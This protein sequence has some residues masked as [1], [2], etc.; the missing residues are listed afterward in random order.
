MFDF[1][2]GEK[3]QQECDAYIGT[4]LDFDYNPVI[5]IQTSKHKLISSI[6]SPWNNPR[7]LFCYGHR[8]P[9]FACILSFIVHDFILVTHN[10][11]Y[12]IETTNTVNCILNCPKLIH[13]FG[14][15]VAISHPKI[16]S[17]PIGLANSMWEHGEKLFHKANITIPMAKPKLVYFNFKI[18]TN[19]AKRTLCYQ[20]C[21]NKVPWLEMTS[22]HMNLKRLS[23]YQFCI[24]PE[25]NGFDTHRMWEC[26]YLNV[27]PIVIDSPFIRKLPSSIPMVILRNW[28]E[29][30]VDKLHYS[31][32]CFDNI[33]LLHMN[34]VLRMIQSVGL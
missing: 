1:V 29:L 4:T 2:T 8:V 19:V 12:N 15:N 9:D 31:D 26:L 11:D 25:G 16:T 5:R 32:F 30:D 10:S 34:H 7:I 13:W 28:N 18:N 3:I 21:I 14:Q 20:S 23:E 17:I 33:P 22:P 6:R 24:C 27:V